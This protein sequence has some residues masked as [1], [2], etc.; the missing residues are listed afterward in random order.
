VAKL[1]K[2]SK[3]KKRNQKKSAPGVPSTGT[4]SGVP[5][6]RKGKWECEDCDTNSGITEKNSG[7]WV[8][9]WGNMRFGCGGEWVWV[10]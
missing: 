3:R 2:L 10:N 9:L 7:C 4:S 5:Q 6:E 1:E 8:G